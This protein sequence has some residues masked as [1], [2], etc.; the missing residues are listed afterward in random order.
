MDFRKVVIIPKKSKYEFDKSR[1]GLN[2]EELIEFYKKQGIRVERI[3]ESHDKQEANLNKLKEIFHESRFIERDDFT[4][5]IALEADL[6]ISFG[7]DNHFT[8]LSHFIKN[9]PILGINSDS[10]RSEGAM[11]SARAEELKEVYEKLESG[12]YE[13]EEWPRL[14]V[15]VNGQIV[16]TL[17][18]SELFLGEGSRKEMSRNILEF[19]GV[20]E[21]QKGAGMIVS[22]GVGSTGW[23]LSATRYLE[24]DFEAFSRTENLAKFVMSEP[25]KGRT[26]DYSLITGEI[27][28]GEELIVHSINDSNGVISFD[29]WKDYPFKEGSIAKIGL[30]ESLK[31]VSFN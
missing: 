11:T 29:S 16:D 13:I 22:T 8:Y 3:K 25:Y 7:G 30:G 18:V 17:A 9:R 23:Y 31:V 14:S 27:K 24:G 15:E 19:K 2:E 28:P 20:K 6:I 26:A 1:L 10:Q 4:K 21:Q 12:K 5:E